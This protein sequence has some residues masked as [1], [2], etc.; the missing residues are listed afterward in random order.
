MI[1]VREMRQVLTSQLSAARVIV[2]MT[3]VPFLTAYERDV[4]LRS[5]KHGV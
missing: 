2:D 3:G 5:K 1:L 4:P